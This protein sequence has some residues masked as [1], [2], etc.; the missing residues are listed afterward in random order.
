MAI[1]QHPDGGSPA[2]HGEILAGVRTRRVSNGILVTLIVAVEAAWV[3]TL[4]AALVWLIL[5]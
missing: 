5:R 3:V 4:V 1:D 2:P